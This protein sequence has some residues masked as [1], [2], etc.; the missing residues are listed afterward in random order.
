MYID[1]DQQSQVYYQETAALVEKQKSPTVFKKTHMYDYQEYKLYLRKIQTFGEH[2]RMAKQ[3]VWSYTYFDKTTKS[4]ILYLKKINT[5]EVKWIIII[6][7]RKVFPILAT[8]F[9]ICI[10]ILI[11][12]SG[13]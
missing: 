7:L 5:H 2:N 6:Y 3:F 8:S 10:L 13:E 4:N 1:V 11:G 9:K 12:G